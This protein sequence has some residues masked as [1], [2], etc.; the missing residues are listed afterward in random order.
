MG[1]T[2]GT[3]VWEPHVNGGE[4]EGGRSIVSHRSLDSSPPFVYW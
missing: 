3:Y 1:G 4:V 2:L